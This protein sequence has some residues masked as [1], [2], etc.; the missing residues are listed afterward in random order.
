MECIEKI[1]CPALSFKER[2]EIDEKCIG[3]MICGQICPE[4]AIYKI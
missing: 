4:G 1:G 3:C 2:I